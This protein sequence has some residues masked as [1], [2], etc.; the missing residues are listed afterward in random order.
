[1]NADLAK[2]LEDGRAARRE[3]VRA[4]LTVEADTKV[5]CSFAG[6][7]L[8][9]GDDHRCAYEP[10]GVRDVA[11]VPMAACSW[12]VEHGGDLHPDVIPDW[13][14][15]RADKRAGRTRPKRFSQTAVERLTREIEVGIRDC[16]R[17]MP[18]LQ[19]IDVAHDIAWNVL[20][21][22]DAHPDTVR[23]VCRRYDIPYSAVRR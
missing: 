17:D 15:A 22:T 2:Q 9:V 19:E 16:M 11:G 23:A 7:R 4:A 5:R 12:H 3:R 10:D 13:E 21:C 18:E 1:M 20:Y 8:C 6:C 14:Q